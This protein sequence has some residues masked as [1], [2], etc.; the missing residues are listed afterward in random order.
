[1][2]RIEYADA[3]PSHPASRR[4][5]LTVGGLSAFGLSL[6]TL[7]AR[8]RRDA[9]DVAGFG[10][11][12][13]CI[14]LW[15][16]GGPPQHE[17]WDPKPDAPAEV[18]GEFRP[19]DSA[20]PGLRV[21]ELMPLVAQQTQRICV[22]RAMSTGINAHSSS[23]YWVLTGV[24]HPRGDVEVAGQLTAADW[25]CVG[26]MVNRL[27]PPRRGLPN[28]VTLP[29]HILNNPNDPWPGQ[30]AGFLGRA[31]DPW[32][33]SCDPS[34][35]DF[36]L[37]EVAPPTDVPPLR[38]DERRA[39]LD[40][41]NKHT[42]RLVAGDLGR[43]APNV[44]QAFDLLADRSARKAFDL[45]AEADRV[46]E[47][48]GRGKFGQSCLVARRLVEAGVRLV[49]V[50]WPREPG[51][52]SS[53]NPLWDT[54][55]KNAERLKTVLMPQMDRAYSALLEDLAARGLLDETLVVWVGEF[56][57]TP[58]I[59]GGGGRDHW[60]RVFSAAL[61]G[62]GVRGGRV[63]G[64]SDKIGADPVDGLTR[65]EELTASI[66]H[67]LGIRPDTEIHDPLGR[68]HPISRGAMIRKAF[69]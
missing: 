50:N 60:G 9:P 29:E 59:N 35:P 38:F 18:R 51:D 31:W 65:P 5:F 66:F 26:A 2:L 3:R 34:R 56:G 15:I 47:R 27:T 25:P 67:A 53:G 37:K 45:T 7:L 10:R 11:A 52:T 42:D 41:V 39:L 13:A 55:S 17:T 12:K 32:L 30:N 64:A 69:A 68:P 49:Q 46:R 57:R 54:H 23:G 1:M 61:A 28:V 36:S 40:Q 8:E 22:L 21:G 20:T 14:L 43:Y 63:L 19:I 44:Q 48:Y 4:E 24:P 6:P 58:K 16:G 62:G 33:V